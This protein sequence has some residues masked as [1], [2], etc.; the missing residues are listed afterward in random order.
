MVLQTGSTT[1]CIDNSTFRD[2][3]PTKS[4]L[5]VFCPRNRWSYSTVGLSTRWSKPV[6]RQSYYLL[7]NRYT[8]P[9]QCIVSPTLRYMFTNT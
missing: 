8:S 7:D 1:E 4:I 9:D 6:Y 5:A 2:D 3:S